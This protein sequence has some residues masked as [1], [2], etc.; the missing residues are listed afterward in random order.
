MTTQKLMKRILLA[1]LALYV[2]AGIARAG[3]DLAG[4][5]VTPSGCRQAVGEHVVV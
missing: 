4:E 2:L 3:T 1:G 5:F